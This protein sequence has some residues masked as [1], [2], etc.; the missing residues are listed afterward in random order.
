MLIASLRGRLYTGLAILTVGMALAAG[1]LAYRWAFDEAI[2]LQDAILLQVGSLAAS[3]HLSTTLPSEGNIDG[4]AQ[5]LIEEIRP[6]AA[7]DARGNPASQLPSDLPDGFQTVMRG[8][9]QWRILVRTRS[10]GS[11]VAV[12]QPTANRDEVAQDSALRTIVPLGVLIPCLMVLIAVVVDRSLRPLS[13]LARHL[14]AK[15]TDHLEKLPTS[16]IPTELLPFV[17]SI[18]RLLERIAMMFDKQRRFVADAAHELRTPITALV[19]QAENLDHANLSQDGRERLSSLKTGIRRTG[20]LLEQLL[21]LARYDNGTSADGPQTE[22]GQILKEVV[23][24]LLPAA[25]DKSVDLG[26]VRIVSVSVRLE[27]VALTVLARNLLDNALRHTPA[28]GQVD[29]SLF[30]E[31]EFVVFRVDDTGSGIPDADLDRIFEPF[32]RGSRSQGEGTG[33]GLSIARRIVDRCHGSIRLQNKPSAEGPGLRATVRFP[34][35]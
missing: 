18:N 8:G 16:A 1:Y 13:R 2:E 20:H 21:A 10:D 4:E 31:N 15:Q 6:G 24:D 17:A 29:V 9:T 33:L 14:D 26:F 23:A 22:F 7:A 35:K 34:L 30:A 27:P 19:V 28:G 5:V 32:F 3:N 12:G 11:R 25:R